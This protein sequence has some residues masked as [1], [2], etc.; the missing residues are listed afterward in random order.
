MQAR[1][2]QDY[3]RLDHLISAFADMSD[4]WKKIAA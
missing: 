2:D 1:T 3:D 4:S